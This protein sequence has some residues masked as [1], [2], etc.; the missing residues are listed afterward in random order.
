MKEISDNKNYFFV[1]EAGDPVFYNKYGKNIVGTEGCS[2]ILIL[3]FIITK[4]PK[5]IRDEIFKLKKE[6][7]N[8]KYLQNIPS[9]IKTKK[10]F[11]AKDD[12]PEIREKF[13]KMILKLDFK[14]EFIVARKNE[15]IFK[16]KYKGKQN[17]FYDDLIIKLFK[18]KLHFSKEND[19]YFEVRGNKKRQKPLEDAIKIAVN[20][21]ESEW[22]IKNNC[23]INIY[24]MSSVGE[25]CL[26][27]ADYINWAVFRA[28]TKKEDRFLKFVENKISFLFDVY[29]F[30]KYPKNFYNR[31]NKFDIN[32]I[33]PL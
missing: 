24:P 29:D 7:Q 19:I 28:Y 17:L 14:A 31:K 21:F 12:C 20:T 11:H 3:G 33:S 8:D 5:I 15:K 6:I 26:S 18:N 1:D 30:N 27:I 22:N 25:P 32:K 16:S 9:M 2:K 4:N 23:K 10:Y 13:F